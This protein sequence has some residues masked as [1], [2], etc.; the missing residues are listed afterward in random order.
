MTDIKQYEPL[1]GA[2]HVDSIIGEGSF[3]KVYKIKKEEF[4]KTYWS[5]MKVLSVPQSDDDLNHARSEGL[6]EASVRS[7]F[8]AFVSDIIQEVDL[9]YELR[10]NSNIVS[11]EE[12]K[13]I[14]HEGK[15]GW[16]IFIRME[17]LQSLT[18]HAMENPLSQYEIAR[19][20][21]HICRALELC[22]LKNII[23][24]DI[25]PDNILISQHGEYK[26][27]D[28]G[29][30]RQ[31]ER[32][33]M[34]L[35][36]KGSEAY[37]APEVFKGG[38][39]GASVDTYSLG[40][41]MYRYLNQNRS[42]FLPDFPNPITPRS[43]EEALLR[44]MQGEPLPKIEGAAP[45]LLAIVLKAC[46]Y[47]RKER[48]A[49][50]TEMREALEKIG[51]AIGNAFEDATEQ[52]KSAGGAII[53]GDWKTYRRYEASKVSGKEAE[54]Q[55]ESW[56]P[57]KSSSLAPKEPYTVVGNQMKP[58][59]EGENNFLSS[60]LHGNMEEYE[61]YLII[62]SR[63]EGNKNRKIV[64][65]FRHEA[66][67]GEGAHAVSN[68]PFMALLLGII[69]FVNV[70]EIV[71]VYATQGIHQR[72]FITA[73]L[74]R[75]MPSVIFYWYFFRRNTMRA[76]VLY[77]LLPY[78]KM[79]RSLLYWSFL[80]GWLVSTLRPEMLQ[81]WLPYINRALAF[82]R[83]NWD[84]TAYMAVSLPQI[85]NGIKLIGS[86]ASFVSGA[87]LILDA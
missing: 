20:G 49:G 65:R 33:A 55:E 45:S 25:K 42:P 48:F 68:R 4:G 82:V 53:S 74:Y 47:D 22:A 77:R 23:H 83:V 57:V 29:I 75:G 39:Y 72:P 3:G 64:K 7:Y 8:R 6:D 40:I 66:L 34:G 54:A 5:A 12:H 59:G 46:A 1:W 21:I 60:G 32:T 9:M 61:K 71:Y 58:Q 26:L 50:A 36:K 24:R 51:N 17:L 27:G 37:M 35:S 85:P 18:E 73:L 14:E 70:T 80:L 13:V 87:F 44:R 43:R 10:G 56:Q 16:D 76:S 84:V 81:V 69:F 41:V 86:F 79:F 30:A 52:T 62:K 28:F 2:W 19:L 78:P 63:L 11:L 15:I 38:E 31:I 67:S